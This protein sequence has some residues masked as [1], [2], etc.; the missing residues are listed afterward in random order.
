M[1]L[2]SLLHA[3]PPSVQEMQRMR[4]NFKQYTLNLPPS[5]QQ[6]QQDLEHAIKEGMQAL[7]MWITN[8]THVL[9]SYKIPK[10]VQLLQSTLGL[11][12][13]LVCVNEIPKQ[14]YYHSLALQD[15]IIHA[16]KVFLSHY[17]VGGAERGN[18]WHWE[19][20]I[21]KL[22]NEI[23]V[24]GYDWIPHHLRLELLR[25][26]R[27]YQPNPKYSG[28]SQGAQFSTNPK[29]R[30]SQG[31]NRVDTA[32]ISLIRGT[33]EQNPTG[34]QE[35]LEAI[36]IVSQSVESGNGFY[37]DGSF[38]Q[39]EHVPSNG[40]Y[41]IVL[42]NG[43]AQF[44]LVL[45]HT[46]YQQ[47]NLYSNDLYA[48]ILKSYPYLLINGG[49]NPSVCGRSISRDFENDTSRAHALLGDLAVLSAYVPPSYQE[50]LQSFIQ[51]SIQPS[52][53]KHIKNL[54][55]RHALE[56][57]L[58][59]PILSP[60]KHLPVKIFG[61]MDRA[62][63]LG[64]HGG[65]IVLAMHSN[66]IL[67]Y[68]TMN[69]ENLKGFYTSDG[70]TY[71]Y[72]GSKDPFM[73]YWVSADMFKL[74]GTTEIMQAY[75]DP[76][77]PKRGKLSPN[78]WVGGASNGDYGFVGMDF[79]SMNG[80]LRAKKS[81]L[82]LGDE[83]LALGSNIDTSKPAI[84]TIDNQKINLNDQA[85]VY[86]NNQ[87]RQN[88]KG[89]LKKGDWIAY[90]NLTQHS[91]IGYVMVQEA[92]ISIQMVPRSGSYQAIGGQSS[93][94]LRAKYLEI[95][96][97]AQSDH[98][99]YLI[100][101]HFGKEQISHYPIQDIVILAQNEKYHAV[102]VPS[103]HLL[104]I[105]KWQAGKLKVQDLTLEDALSILEI[106]ADDHVQL[107]IAD[108]TQQ[109][110]HPTRLSLEGRY[111]LMSS[112]PNVQITHRHNQ[113]ILTLTLP[114]IGASLVVDLRLLKPQKQNS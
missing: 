15:R 104:A 111:T 39:H 106:K 107:S 56:K 6:N 93:Q 36:K 83:M 78:A 67:N 33:L 21:P 18:W 29:A 40:S 74:P 81:Y 61:A 5:T 24:M 32:L 55:K 3:S 65:K 75:S 108:P 9:N 41:G 17:V 73:D 64:A 43:L 86:L 12:K 103:K 28:L 31:A 27:Y 98:Y 11:I 77:T 82:F 26:Q 72:G 90:E 101:P 22:L 53:L 87:E 37:P 25:A 91:S 114:K 30:L 80:D 63:Q 79:V 59:K 95:T 20:G 49:I 46:H 96:L 1:M 89:H 60:T 92:P 62:V 16:L 113:T 71:I 99:A 97:P 85:R 44:M 52:D 102:Q 88:F 76:G 100:L 66:R 54:W 110:T 112:N 4:L 50:H 23:L 57:I 68:E 14:P 38:I 19:I 51:A 7:D 13:D 94:E 34:I 8:S 42:L 35:A 70:M 10:R 58:N 2:A 84:T 45:D 105:N 69:G 109:L 47:E 48:N